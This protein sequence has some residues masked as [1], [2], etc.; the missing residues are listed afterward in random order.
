MTTLA[1]ALRDADEEELVALLRERPDLAGPPPPS[2]AVIAKRAGT[3]ASIA[4]AC[5]DLDAFALAVLEALVVAGAPA[6]PVESEAVAALLGPDVP[7][8]RLTAALDTLRIRALAWREPDGRIAVP[9]AAA[10]AVSPHPGGLGRPSP[11]LTGDVAAAVAALP[12]PERAVLDKLAGASPL[13]RSAASGDS[14]DTADPVRQLLAK[15]LLMRR[16]AQ[17]VELPRQ[18]GL[19]VR[20]E[21]PM[22]TVRPDPPE[23]ETAPAE[24]PALDA[25]AATE[26]LTLGRHV[27]AMLEQWSQDPPQRLRSG[28]LGVRELRRIAASLDVD[29]PHAALLVELVVAADL[30]AVDESTEGGEWLPTTH[31]DGWLAAPP[32]QR[33]AELA[34]TWLGLTRLPGLAGSRDA[35][36]KALAA[37]GDELR[38]P[39]APDDRRRILGALAERDEGTAVRRDDL[40]VLLAWR[41]PRR[42]GRLR[43][44]L[45]DQ[46][47]REA[48]ILGVTATAGGGAVALSTPGRA[49]LADTDGGEEAALR[50]AEALPDP[51][52]HVLIQADLTMIAPGPLPPN[53]AAEIALVADAE[54]T[55]SAT[56]YRVSESSVR[57]ALDAGRGADDLH[58][59]FR[60][61]SA[62]PV[63]QGLTYLIDDV[64]RRHGRLRAG[65]AGSFLRSDH[66]VLLTE[67]MAHRVAGRLELRRLAPTVLVSP[68][69]LAAVLAGLREAG[70]APAGEAPDGTVLDLRPRARRTSPGNRGMQRVPAPNRPTPE[71][72]RAAARQARAGDRAAGT[73]TGRSVSAAGGTGASATIAGTL[74][75]LRDAERTGSRVRLDVVDSRGTA[76]QFVLTPQRIGGGA[77]LG[78]DPD[79]TPHHVPLHLVTTAA[80]VEE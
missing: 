76:N 16:D 50:M 65:T 40:A 68:L 55:G 62:T 37:L 41:R 69:P 13:G 24:Q 31:A 43:D 75:V 48:R 25:A 71:Q 73:R 32:E 36:G 11:E 2:T 10:D 42:G 3:M 22:G 46:V 63:P 34:T 78:E 45:V 14:G 23:P 56:V 51:V 44:E 26:V 8:G 80:I 79:G 66:D 60:T 28:G 59:L 64:A 35:K 18:V 19:A 49:L 53:L 17:T 1:D 21:R 30:A 15:G 54:S 12:D 72:V 52:E 7:A 77:L 38:R 6:R 61:R 39:L 74:S 9:P 70:F 57:R 33:W 20:G 4:R 67:V 5:D 58:E 47:L 27:E 29:E